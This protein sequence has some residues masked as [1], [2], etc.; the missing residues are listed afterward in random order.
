VTKP[1]PLPDLPDAIVS[2]L[3]DS[4]AVHAHSAAVVTWIVPVDASAPTL[5]LAGEIVYTHGAG[6]G[7]GGGGGGIGVGA[8]VGVGVGAGAGSGS[9]L[10]AAWSTVTVCCAMVTVPVRADKPMFLPTVKI[11]VPERVP[12][13]AAGTAIHGA[14]LVAD[15][16]QPVSVSTVT[17]IAPPF[18]DTVALAGETPYRHGAA[19]CM[20]ATWILLTS[21]VA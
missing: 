4:A 5:S 1:F 9:G 2:Q 10:G 14:A 19:S 12:D 7:V 6:D 20:T 8:G 15:H 17:V 18:A 13:E 16:A 11:S 21:T 3:L